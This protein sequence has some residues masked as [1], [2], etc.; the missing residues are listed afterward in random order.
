MAQNSIGE[1]VVKGKEYHF[2]R[3]FFKIQG[4][5]EDERTMMLVLPRC[6]SLFYFRFKPDIGYSLL[7]Q[8]KGKL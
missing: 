6:F 8:F 3:L 1:N 2:P 7:P 5:N 4:I